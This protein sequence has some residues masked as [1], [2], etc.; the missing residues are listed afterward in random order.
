MNNYRTVVGKFKFLNDLQSS[1][2]SLVTAT[3]ARKVCN[4]KPDKTFTRWKIL[5]TGIL[6]SLAGAG[7][8]LSR[9]KS[10]KYNPLQLGCST[11]SIYTVA[12]K[13]DFF[14]FLDFL[15]ITLIKLNYTYQV[16]YHQKEHKK[17]Y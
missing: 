17:L 9:K 8:Q 10:R 2:F 5:N 11:K 3:H 7:K 6:C 16:I 14:I 15:K 12:K 1:L 13:K 4:W